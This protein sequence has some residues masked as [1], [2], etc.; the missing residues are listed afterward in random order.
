MAHVGQEFALG[1]VV[2]DT[3]EH[4]AMAKRLVTL[5]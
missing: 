4:R 5:R 3:H 2:D 1:N